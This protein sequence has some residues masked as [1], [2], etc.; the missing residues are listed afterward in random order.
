[1]NSHKGKTINRLIAHYVD[2]HQGKAI[3][4]LIARYVDL[5][6]G[7]TINWLIAIDLLTQVFG[8]KSLLLGIFVALSQPSTWIVSPKPHATYQTNNITHNL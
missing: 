5:Q 4:R 8:C 7:K 6:K 1:M 2:S 3:N